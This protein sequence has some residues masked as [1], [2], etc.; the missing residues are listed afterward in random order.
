M[1]SIIFAPTFFQSAGEFSE[2]V[3]GFITHVKSSR[4]VTPDGEILMPGEPEA[5]ARAQRIRD[6]IEIDDTTWGQIVATCESL[7]IPVELTAR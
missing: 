4:T 5:R 3:R 1:L 7:G 2:D 6:G